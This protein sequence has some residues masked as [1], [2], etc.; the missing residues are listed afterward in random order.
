MFSHMLFC[1]CLCDVI[2]RIASVFGKSILISSNKSYL[3]IVN[4]K[5]GVSIKRKK[6]FPF[7]VAFVIE[8]MIVQNNKLISASNDDTIAVATLR[9]NHLTKIFREIEGL[10]WRKTFNQFIIHIADSRIV[11]KI[12]ISHKE[13]NR[14]LKITVVIVNT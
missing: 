3:L 6:G 1:I 11:V 4:I 10:Y 2:L 5:L 7:D 13:N 12:I 9:I 8:S 14:N